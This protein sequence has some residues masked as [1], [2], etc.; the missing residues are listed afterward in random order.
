[1]AGRSHRGA[2]A[3]G[4]G[5]GAAFNM[6][7]MIDVTF[8]LII[9]FVV[10]GQIASDALAKME[11]AK[12]E[13]SQALKPEVADVPNKVLINVLSKGA[14]GEDVDPFIA[15]RVDWYQIEGHRV[16]PGRLDELIS[17]IEK[18][19]NRLAE[20]LQKEF[21]VE[22]RADRR[23]HFSGVEPVLTAAVA[24]GVTK[25]NITAVLE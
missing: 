6:T 13:M 4:R 25:M 15:G 18:K 12:P 8:Q 9:F 17:I 5:R 21:F 24:A 23:V 19:K 16:L 20:R 3:R 2:H 1:M 14:V 22:V 10:A 7:P 11:L